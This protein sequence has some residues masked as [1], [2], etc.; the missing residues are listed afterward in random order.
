MTRLGKKLLTCAVA[1]VAA[2]AAPGGQGDYG[3]TPPAGF[4]W[5]PFAKLRGSDTSG[6]DHFGFAVDLQGRRLVVAAPGSYPGA[7][8]L[9][10][11]DPATGEWTERGRL[12]V[13][14]EPSI[15]DFGH[16]LALQD[17]LLFVS[18]PRLRTEPDGD[19]AGAVHVF[20]EEVG[21][22]ARL[23][24][25]TPSPGGAFGSSLDVDGELL[26]V[27]AWRERDDLGNAHLFRGHGAEWVEEAVLT[28]SGDGSA[29]WDGA[30][31]A[32]GLDGGL[33]VLG[34][35]FD[36]TAAPSGGAVY[37][38]ESDGAG[39]W[40]ETA[41]LT[42]SDSEE[43]DHF[44]VALDLEGERVVVQADGDDEM[45]HDAGAAYVF[46][47][48]GGVWSEVAKLTAADGGS[49]GYFGTPAL[50]GDYLALGAEGGAR[51]AV[52]LH[53]RVRGG[54]DAWGLVA[55]M[56]RNRGSWYLGI[57]AAV[58]L[59][60]PLVV[61]GAPTPGGLSTADAAYTFRPVPVAPEV[62]VEGTCPG[63]VR[64]EARGLTPDA[65]VA[66]FGG[67]LAG[68][69][70]VDVGPC[71]GVELGIEDAREAVRRL[72]TDLEGEAF[73]EREIDEPRCGDLFQVV[74]LAACVKGEVEALPAPVAV[75]PE[76][77][78]GG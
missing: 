53:H 37:V 68:L 14:G 8:Y 69:T 4:G 48:D 6:G 51:G 71:R 21:E 40:L 19:G 49:F 62:S 2:A 38:F 39:G 66:V 57:G 78:S 52:Y 13:P 43:F 44:G 18:S 67:T 61:A 15:A 47:R 42:A 29:D 75:R 1:G 34:A 9:F 73:L 28:P 24:S 59:Q 12:E 17:D 33:A 10:H 56:G 32:V 60:V 25:S 76:R 36:D 50:D 26:L 77:S 30:G 7:V 22:V 5:T 16:D 41:T 45:A 11:L 64:V 20:E 54:E 58:D 74:E 31:A 46:E 3:S 35:I 72:R 70:V 27:G 65:W 55:K 23:F 63:E